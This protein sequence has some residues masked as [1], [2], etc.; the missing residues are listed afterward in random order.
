MAPLETGIG[1]A[2]R[3]EDLQSIIENH[4]SSA[5]RRKLLGVRG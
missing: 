2:T 1:L 5:G 3:Y 4:G